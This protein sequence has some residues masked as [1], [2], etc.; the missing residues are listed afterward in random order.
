MTAKDI[1]KAIRSFPNGSTGGPDGLKPQHLKDMIGPS[2]NS[3]SLLSALSRFVEM[4][5]EGRTPASWRPF[6]FGANLTALQKK[7]GD[8][9]PIAV[10][11]TLRRLAAKVIGKR[12]GS[13]WLF[14]NWDTALGEDL[15][16][17]YMPQGSI[18]MIFTLPRPSSS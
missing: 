2:A 17:Q 9:R 13:F 5:L 16:Q 15:K 4:V 3:C 10:G 12:W 7:T 1:L 14:G 6:F 8:I 18:C 11:C